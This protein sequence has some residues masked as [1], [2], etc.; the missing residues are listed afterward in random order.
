MT[1]LTHWV[2]IRADGQDGVILAV[3][4]ETLNEIFVDGGTH[5]SLALERQPAIIG[6][7][8]IPT[9]VCTIPTEY[10]HR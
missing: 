9:G 7:C 6:V 1:A 3:R 10:E 2:T 8:T 4:F 5:Y